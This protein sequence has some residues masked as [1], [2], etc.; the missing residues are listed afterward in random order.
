M[1]AEFNPTSEGRRIAASYL[2]KRGWA[3]EWRQILGRQVYP[4]VQRLASESRAQQCDRLEHE[5][6]EFFDDEIKR[7]ENDPSEQAKEVLL[8]IIAILGRRRDLGF[9]AEKIVRRLSNKLY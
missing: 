2:S 7:Y 3:R 6:E 4:S 5:A 1:A 8:T 9:Y